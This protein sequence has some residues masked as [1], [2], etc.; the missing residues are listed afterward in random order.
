MAVTGHDNLR[1]Y[2]PWTWSRGSVRFF[3]AG[4]YFST[5]VSSPL[6]CIV[7]SV[8]L[9]TCRCKINHLRPLQLPY[10]L[11]ERCWSCR[12]PWA[13]EC[14]TPLSGS[15]TPMSQRSTPPPPGS[16]CIQTGHDAT[17]TLAGSESPAGSGWSHTKKTT[18]H[19]LSEA[20]WWK[21]L[22]FESFFSRRRPLGSHWKLGWWCWVWCW[23]SSC[24]VETCLAAGKSSHTC[25]SNKTW[26][27]LMFDIVMCQRLNVSCGHQMSWKESHASVRCLLSSPVAR[28][29]HSF[30]WTLRAPVL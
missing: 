24:S 23:S 2:V 19:Q 18:E 20:F 1:K 10:R 30:T 14:T 12:L 13:A 29:W 11:N 25:H 21:G 4:M 28:L 15:R 9:S 17:Q 6:Y 3:S 5:T 16:C 22:S 27:P 8:L 7:E 26:L